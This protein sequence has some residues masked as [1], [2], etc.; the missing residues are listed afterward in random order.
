MKLSGVDGQTF[1]QAVRSQ[2]FGLTSVPP[3]GAEGLILALGG[4]LDR[5]WALGVE[6]PQHRPTGLTSGASTFYDANGNRVDLNSAGVTITDLSGNV[7]STS[8]SKI[9]VKPAGTVY[10]GGDGSTGSYDF[11]QTVSG[12]SINVKARYA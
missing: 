2:H 4:G 5:A 12:P 1:G 7:V 8:A 6:H 11:V 9:T 3:A 10:L